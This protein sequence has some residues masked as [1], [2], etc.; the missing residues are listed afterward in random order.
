MDLQNKKDI[1]N[2]ILE[3]R[4]KVD[5]D[6]RK[7]WDK[8][9]FS[10]LINSDFY[11][12]A[13]V[14]FAFV[15]FKSEVE[16][17]QIIKQALKDSKIIYVP[18]IRSREKGMEIFKIDSLD[19][20]KTGYFGILEPQE[21][22]P[23][24]GSSTIDLILMPGVAFDRQGGRLGYGR[25][26]YDSFLR[27]MNKRV[28]KIALAYDFQILDKVPMDEFDVKIDGFITNEGGYFLY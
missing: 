19:E 13:S 5:P 8:I 26:Y 25:G 14:I 6:I 15:S 16:T 7:E 3:K 27:K 21:S 22:C 9:I 18:K 10:N 4:E 23:A 1:R 12:N 24:A 17:H 28:D 2:F 11:K 20:L